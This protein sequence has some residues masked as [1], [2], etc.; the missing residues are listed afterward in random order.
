[1]ML[2]RSSVLR[3]F[4]GTAAAVL[5]GLSASTHPASA[6]QK[7]SDVAPIP[8]PFQY[9][10]ARPLQVDR[11]ASAVWQDLQKLKTRAS[12][13]MIV[14]HPDDEDGPMLTFESRQMGVDTSLLTL[15]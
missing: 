11:G 4:A 8:P 5:F 3:L 14:A 2:K 1:M 13:I 6:Q 9:G 15:T 10:K 7:Q 12:L